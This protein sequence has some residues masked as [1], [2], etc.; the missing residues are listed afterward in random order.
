MTE[1]YFQ[2]FLYRRNDQFIDLFS[3]ESAIWLIDALRGGRKKNEK[4]KCILLSFDPPLA[5]PPI[6]FNWSE[7]D[8]WYES[9]IKPG[10]EFYARVEQL[11]DQSE[12]PYVV[13]LEKKKS[14]TR[15]KISNFVKDMEKR[16]TGA[17]FFLAE[18][19][20]PLTSVEITLLKVG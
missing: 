20:S 1:S 13:F 7:D 9:D 10:E 16:G 14:E 6:V 15:D 17:K 3:S 11:I 18:Y 12:H 4:K 8:I 2:N 5:S 19:T